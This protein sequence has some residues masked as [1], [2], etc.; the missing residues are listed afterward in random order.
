M[1]GDFNIDGGVV[2]EQAH[3]IGVNF[4]LVFSRQLCSKNDAT[5]PRAGNEDSR[6]GKGGKDML[7]FIAIHRKPH[8]VLRRL[9]VQPRTAFG[10]APC[11]KLSVDGYILQTAVQSASQY[12]FHTLNNKIDDFHHR[13]YSD[14]SLR[15]F[16]DVA[17][18]VFPMGTDDFGIETRSISPILNRNAVCSSGL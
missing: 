7:A 4:V 14:M 13:A 12:I 17:C 6:L 16:G 18:P 5:L 2:G 11:L 9:A 15:Y 8:T 3:F 1:I 10:D